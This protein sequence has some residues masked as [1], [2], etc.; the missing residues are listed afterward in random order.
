[1]G[2][3]PDYGRAVA[4]QSDGKIL[5]AGS[6]SIPTYRDFTLLRYN[7]NGSLDTNFNGTG[8]VT[9][10]MSS[11]DDYGRGIAVQGDGKILV[12]GYAGSA[13]VDFALARY[14]T[15]GTLDTTFNSTGR[16]ITPV[17]TGDDCG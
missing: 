3:G 9:T 5:L 16:I 6:A 11:Y 7:A 12:A 10:P 4:I 8:K 15:N 14:E 1:M 13:Y 17:G 2:T